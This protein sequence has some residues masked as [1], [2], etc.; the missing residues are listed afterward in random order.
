MSRGDVIFL[1]GGYT[2]HHWCPDDRQEVVEIVREC[3]EAYGLQFEPEGADKDAVEVEEFYLRGEEGGEF[4][5][6]REAESGKLVGSG[7]FYQ[8]EVDEEGRRAAEIRKMYLLP[9]ARGKKLG[10]YLLEVSKPG[11]QRSLT[12]CVHNDND[13]SV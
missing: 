6:V 5:V 10:R 2:A 8:V 3:L 1:F 13:I 12:V 9:E 7:G 4:W 11:G